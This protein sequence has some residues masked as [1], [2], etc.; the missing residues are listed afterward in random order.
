MEGLSVKLNEELE[1][2]F[3]KRVRP[4]PYPGTYAIISPLSLMA[5]DVTNRSSASWK[6]AEHIFVNGFQPDGGDG[7]LPY[8]REFMRSDMSTDEHIQKLYINIGD[9][10][11][12]VF[13]EK[14]DA[15]AVGTLKELFKGG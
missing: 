2:L 8:W 12:K 11:Y 14:S 9:G 10:R 4:L 13:N 7:L 6:K 5:E 3:L 15:I 1:G